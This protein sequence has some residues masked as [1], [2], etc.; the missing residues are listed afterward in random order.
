MARR[1]DRQ[2]PQPSA[3]R[4]ADD[5]MPPYTPGGVPEPDGR[6]PATPAEKTAPAD[7]YPPKQKP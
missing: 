1:L 5:H 6:P 3:K 2:P 7:S 4:P